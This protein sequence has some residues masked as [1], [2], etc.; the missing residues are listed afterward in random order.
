MQDDECFSQRVLREGRVRVPL[1]EPH[2]PT[3]ESRFAS[4][5]YHVG[6]MVDVLCR[7]GGFNF[8]WAWVAGDVNVILSCHALHNRHISDFCVFFIRR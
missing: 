3:L 8:T 5:L 4:G 1:D 6:E 2:I 7:I